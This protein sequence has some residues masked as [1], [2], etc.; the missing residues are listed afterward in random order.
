MVSLP[1]SAGTNWNVLLARQRHETEMLIPAIPDCVRRGQMIILAD[2]FF[3]SK[4]QVWSTGIFREV[5]TKSTCHVQMQAVT[6]SAVGRVDITTIESCMLLPSRSELAV[7]HKGY[8]HSKE[9][10]IRLGREW[11]ASIR[12]AK[13][14]VCYQVKRVIG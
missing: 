2:R 11:F 5:C 4:A 13:A 10:G 8:P 1:F 3:L 12:C 9:S 14:T 7:V 6:A